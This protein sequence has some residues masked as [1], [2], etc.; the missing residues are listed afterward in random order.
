MSSQGLLR[1][2]TLSM[3]LPVDL[4]K[5]V[6]AENDSNNGLTIVTK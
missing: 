2:L 6:N 5:Y 1:T 3:S 4:P